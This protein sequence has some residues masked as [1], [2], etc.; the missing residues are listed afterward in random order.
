LVPPS[1]VA[2][3]WMALIAAALFGAAAP[4]GKVL[5]GSVDAQ[6]LAGLLYLGAAAGVAPFA[7][8]RGG[9]R[10]ALPGDRANSLRLAGAVLA[11]GALGP[12]A[13]L[14]ALRLADATSVSVWL[15]LEL[16]ATAL[17]G[18]W[19]F[20]DH[21]GRPG[22]GGVVLA[23]CASVLL[24]LGG[25]T[26]GWTSGLLILV[27]CLLWG[28]D[29]HLTALLDT[30]SPEASTFWKG[31]AAGGFNFALG[32]LRAPLPPLSASAAA[33]L[34]GAAAYG[35]SIALYIRGAQRLGATRAQTVFCVS[36]LFGLGLSA[37]FLG[38]RVGPSHVG[39]LALFAAALALLIWEQHIHEHVHTPHQHDHPHRHDDGHHDHDHEESAPPGS[40]HTHPHAHVERVHAHPHLPDLHHRHEHAG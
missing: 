16:P 30:L 5:L 18:V 6:Q 19:F 8:G 23:G 38:E 33:L 29:N 21:L 32:A 37:L 7:F 36:P 31:L 17:L 2:P 39:A 20:G 35:A 13:L 15:S 25:G 4:A 10:L 11:G 26:A 3:F 28:L 27:A 1:R 34:L 40:S 14:A 12:L 24:A 9:R 22:W